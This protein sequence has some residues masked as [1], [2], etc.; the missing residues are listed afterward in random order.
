MKNGKSMKN[1][2][3]MKNGKSKDGKNMKK[4]ARIVLG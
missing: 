1:G 3:S 4:R 2:T